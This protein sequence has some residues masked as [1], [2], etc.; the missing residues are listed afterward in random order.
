MMKHDASAPNRDSTSSRS[1]CA[2]AAPPLEVFYV[3]QSTGVLGERDHRLRSDLY[4]TQ[5]Q[6]DVELAG[7]RHADSGGTYSVW[8]S[9]TYI[10]PAEWLHRV[11]RS[12]G[13][14]I[15][16]RL[17]GVEKLTDC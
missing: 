17:R 11:V 5:P 16:P 9:V 15:L 14:L 13:S 1:F 3:V 12:D 4:E 2:A 7:L 8:K 6:A 10:E